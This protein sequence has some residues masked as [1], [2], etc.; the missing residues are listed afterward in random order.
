MPDSK[1][2]G[3][4]LSWLR[5]RR[6]DKWA[7]YGP[8]VLPA[9]VAEMDFPLAP[10][11]Q[12]VLVDAIE[13]GDCGYAHEG[14]I[15][16]AFAEFAKWKF[17]WQLNPGILVLVADIMSGV[18]EL[19]RA[20]T[21][22]GEGVVINPPV[23]PPFYTTIRGV[24]RQIVPVPL[25]E[26]TN[27]WQLDLQ[28][29]EAAFERGVRA[30]LLCNPHNPSG[31]VFSR[32][33]LEAV[34]E[35]ALRFNVLVI[36]DEV[37][38]PLVMPGERHTPY[39]SIPAVQQTTGFTILS[40]S[41]GWNIPA[42][43]CALIVPGSEEVAVKARELLPKDL[44]DRVSQLGIVASVSAFGTDGIR[45]LDELVVYLDDNRRQLRSLLMTELPEVGYQVPE[46]GYLAWLDCRAL[47]LGSNPARHFLDRGR[48][49]LY[50][51]LDF[52]AE[53]EG[54][55]RLNFGTSFRL[56]EEGIKRMRASVSGLSKSRGHS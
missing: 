37:H 26:S 15:R 33:E 20:F 55:V 30:Y 3:L 16:Q 34:A 42:L 46:A 31:R 11:V 53:G 8:D 32:A 5:K 12:K 24:G 43:K 48:V 19:L 2:D 27:G 54:Y 51:G 41:K 7:R 14:Q 38:S 35:L 44:I 1:F 25:R 47:G 22:A 45:W 18:A 39:V 17:D 23:Y 28:G 52:G 9:W 6:S 36:S 50:S 4:S 49:A 40:A 56:V 29:L 21:S 13:L 10:A